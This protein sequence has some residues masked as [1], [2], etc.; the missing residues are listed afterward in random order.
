MS[1][2]GGVSSAIDTAVAN[3]VAAGVVFAVAAG[4]DDV[5]ACTSSPARAPSA[6][7]V[8]ST[9][10]SDARSS[11]SNWGSCLDLFAPGSGI[12]SAWHTGPTATN[13]ISG[14]SMATPHVAGAAA[15]Y[16]SAHPTATPAA[17]RSALISGGTTGRVTGAGAGSPN[18]LLHTTPLWSG[19]T[20]PEPPAPAPALVN[21]GFESGGQG[22]TQSTSGI[23][24]SSATSGQRVR[25]GSWSAWLGGYDGASEALS[26]QVTVPAAGASLSYWWQLSSAEGT[27]TAYDA[28]TVRVLST[29]GALL[30]TL[31]TRSNTAPRG[32]WY[33][34]SLSLSSFAGRTVVLR[35]GATT[36]STA[37]SSYF[38][39]DVQV[40]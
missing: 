8:G 11:F 32:A 39:D 18:V 23:V 19:T 25:T 7:T 35:F 3:A 6:V 13:T 14:T 9:T 21:G 28:M 34:D 29:S 31:R 38:V 17:F 30:A 4:N 27:S 12:T 20:T 36:D 24:G 5:D 2:G 40:G 26:Q 33:A 22:W 37:P 16:L 15:L 1:L 10:S